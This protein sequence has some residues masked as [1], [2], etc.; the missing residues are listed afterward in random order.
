M[1]RH[2]TRFYLAVLMIIAS[3]VQSIGENQNI[4]GWNAAIVRT[5][6]QSKIPVEI[7]FREDNYVPLASFFDNYR[8]IFNWGPENDARS[9]RVF[10]DKLGQTHHRFRQYYNGIEV[11]DIQY[12]LHE[13]DGLVF[14]AHGK[15][16]HGLEID[17]RP[18][19]P[20]AEAL[21]KALAHIHAESYLWENPKSGLYQQLLQNEPLATRSPVGELKISAGHE[22][23]IARNF[24]LVY[25]FDIF[26]VKPFSR[27]YVDIDA[28]TG[29]IVGTYSR[30]NYRDV[31]G[32]GLSVYNGMVPITVSDSDYP[33]WPPPPS[34]WHPDGWQAYGGSGE[35]WWMADPALGDAGGYGDMWYEILDTDPI[36][37][38]G[39]NLML[40]FYHR[41]SVEMPSM[42]AGY[43][44]WDGMNVRISTD[45]GETWQILTD[46]LP[47]YSCENLYS[48][49]GWY[50]EGDDIPGWAGQLNDWAKVTIDLST[51]TGQAV[52]IRFAFASD[53]GACTA[54][55]LP[56]CFGWQID[57]ISVFNSEDTLFSNSGSVSGMTAVNKYREVTDTAGNYRLREEERGGGIATYNSMGNYSMAAS[58]DFVD[59]DSLFNDPADRAGVSLHWGLENAYDYFFNIHGRTSYDGENGRLL[60]YANQIFYSFPDSVWY[61]NNA[62]W[63]GSFSFYGMGDGTYWGPW[64]SLDVVG[65]EI[66]HGVTQ[67]SADLLYANESGGLNESFSDIFGTALE[68]YSEGL[69][70]DWFMGED[71][72]DIT[73]KNLFVRSLQDPKSANNPDTYEGE[74]W[75]MPVE[76]PNEANDYGGVHTNC[77]VQNH[78]FY[79]L[80]Q[81]GSGTN[82]KGYIFNVK[83]IDMAE[84]EQIVYRNLTV[85]LTPTSQY[86]EA[87]WGSIN[88]AIDIF[89]AYSSQLKSVID[90][91][92]AVNVTTSNIAP[93]ARNLQ[94]SRTYLRPD[95]DT[96]SATVRIFNPENH[97][98]EVSGLITNSEVSP[99]DTIALFDD[100]LH[101]DSAA[102][103]GIY[104]TYILAP[105]MEDYYHIDLFTSSLTAGYY[106]VFANAGAFT[107]LGP[108]RFSS[109]RLNHK[110]TLVALKL[111]LENLSETAVARNVSARISTEDSDVAEF[112]I[113]VQNF[114]DIPAGTEKECP[115]VYYFVLKPECLDDTLVSID[116]NLEIF[117]NGQL[118]WT[119][120]SGIDDSTTLMIPVNIAL[121]DKTLPAAYSL[122]QNHP[123]PFNP[124]TAIE[125]TLPRPEYTTLKIYN[126]LGAEVGTLI[127]DHL[128]AGLHRLTFDGSKLASGLY[129]YEIKAGEFRDVK[130]MVLIR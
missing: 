111:S 76:D 51:Y 101:Q 119:D 114:G 56:Q 49:G 1:S 19:I 47:G 104:G 59:E 31:Q 2:F 127:A 20:E 96:L 53:G 46:P 65:H 52:Q 64:V 110:E 106:D 74:Y 91:W 18:A 54:T 7:R 72:G 107:T 61:P 32:Q 38:N 11:A 45:Q 81:G 124:T 24:R 50:A 42:Y 9:F 37:L 39:D 94:L 88:A 25:R 92:N 30:I 95:L 66:T 120:S 44:G 48:F 71:V 115:G 97:L 105:V 63:A 117:S 121:T 80:C 123:N 125:F 75:I 33:T 118:F 21:A 3:S 35:S 58:V 10:T 128:P 60:G 108:L 17:I 126:I 86:A 12:L 122:S 4:A 87:R 85:Y 28:H 109:Y 57:D 99:T 98:V 43:D 78:W 116:L 130:K 67:Y 27:N 83:K 89:G 15:L 77:G 102:G 6:G 129:Y 40:T 29:E 113:D 90:A 100:G 36:S 112:K 8:Q 26:A 16:I 22:E 84:A 82:D 14:L 62:M 41:Y 70:G 5:E 23:K 68:F 73:N 79:L 13:K 55:N 69:G 34:H 103:D 93:Y